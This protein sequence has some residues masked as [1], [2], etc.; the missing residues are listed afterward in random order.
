MD[1]DALANETA[2]LTLRSRTMCK[3][4]VPFQRHRECSAVSENNLQHLVGHANI[5][6]WDRRFIDR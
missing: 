3:P 5:L 4:R 2:A 1:T 6:Y